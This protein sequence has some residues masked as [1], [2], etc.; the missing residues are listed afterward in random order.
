MSLVLSFNFSF[1]FIRRL[2]D[3]LYQQQRDYGSLCWSSGDN[4]FPAIWRLLSKHSVSI[5]EFLTLI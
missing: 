2:S 5:I 1:Y 3:I 4:T